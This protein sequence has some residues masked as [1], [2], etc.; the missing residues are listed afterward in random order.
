MGLRI[1]LYES[2]AAALSYLPW[3]EVELALWP[4][5][6]CFLAR[7]LQRCHVLLAISYCDFAWTSATAAASSSLR[8]IAPFFVRTCAAVIDFLLRV[9]GLFR[10]FQ[11]VLRLLPVFGQSL[12][13][14]AMP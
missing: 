13:A 2:C 5:Q 7:L 1:S 8:G 3:A 9:V 12:E 11:V 14:V 4:L 10:G 6:L